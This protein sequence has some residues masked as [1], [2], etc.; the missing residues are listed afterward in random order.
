MDEPRKARAYC[1]P[2]CRPCLAL[3]E[4]LNYIGLPYEKVTDY[5]NFPKGVTRIP[6][7]EF[8]GEFVAGYD[9]MAISALLGRHNALPR[10]PLWG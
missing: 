2:N 9:R 4:W 1:N 3:C 7:F 6:T 5:R 8:E 10:R